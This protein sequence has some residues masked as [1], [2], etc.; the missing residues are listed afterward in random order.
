MAKTRDTELKLI[1]GFA[2]LMVLFL[3]INAYM[4][5]S[6]KGHPFLNILN[7]IFTGV[8]SGFVVYLL[9]SYWPRKMLQEIKAHQIN[10]DL[11]EIISETDFFQ[12]NITS[13]LALYEDEI[14]NK[15]EE[16][17]CDLVILYRNK[18]IQKV[19]LLTYRILD[20]ISTTHPLYK[21]IFAIQQILLKEIDNLKLSKVED[22]NVIRRCLKKIKE[23]TINMKSVQDTE[24]LYHQK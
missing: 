2:L 12:D 14:T 7:S 23:I 13:S 5:I 10:Y 18:Y 21:D 8:L 22:S 24:N 4:E 19:N 9:T 16:I 20:N 11:R 17:I 1:I 6:D 15:T 3:F